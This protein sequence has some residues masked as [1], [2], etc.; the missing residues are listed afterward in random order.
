MKER[1]M[2]CIPL[3]GD[4]LSHYLCSSVAY[5]SQLLKSVSMIQIH[6][7]FNIFLSGKKLQRTNY[8]FHQ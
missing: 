4:P 5:Q 6:K 3:F 8:T 1:A 2:A 7:C